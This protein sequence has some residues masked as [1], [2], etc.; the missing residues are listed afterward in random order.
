LS[1]VLNLG[2][3]IIAASLLA[4][5]VIEL[6]LE[7]TSRVLGVLAERPKPRD[8]GWG[9]H[10]VDVITRREGGE[11]RLRD[12]AR[13]FAQD[14]LVRKQAVRAAASTVVGRSPTWFG[15][16]YWK[17]TGAVADHAQ[18]SVTNAAMSSVLW[19]VNQFLAYGPGGTFSE[20]KMPD[21][22]PILARGEN[23]PEHRLLDFI[24]RLLNRV[25]YPNFLTP[26]GSEADGLKWNGR[27]WHSS[28]RTK[29][30]RWAHIYDVLGKLREDFVQAAA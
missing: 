16:A 20:H 25:P 30:S 1:R 14:P 17:L 3:Q 2:K 23:Q 13:R 29:D 10:I 5:L 18:S 7:V 28:G 15:G 6:P 21:K 27:K 9:Y 12:C 26:L 11:D 22:M 19:G 24:A 4:P 8:Q